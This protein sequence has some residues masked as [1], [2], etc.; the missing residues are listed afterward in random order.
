MTD[1]WMNGCPLSG[2]HSPAGRTH[3]WPWVGHIAC[4]QAEQ[5]G[6]EG[7]S[8]CMLCLEWR[9]PLVI[10]IFK[11]CFFSS[12]R[13]YCYLIDL[14]SCQRTMNELP[15]KKTKKNICSRR[16]RS[17]ASWAGG[18]LSCNGE[19]SQKAKP[20]NLASVKRK[21]LLT[22]LRYSWWCPLGKQHIPW[23]RLTRSSHGLPVSARSIT[24]LCK[25]RP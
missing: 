24:S 12:P 20:R 25:T 19:G 18:A 22:C 10:T 21:S 7:E 3:R 23:P 11:S 2:L 15:G 16:Q 9:D 6:R 5:E 17:M 13:H 14:P 8:L 4:S 1:G